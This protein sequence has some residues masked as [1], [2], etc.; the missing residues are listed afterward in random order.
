MKNKPSEEELSLIN[1]I[2]KEYLDKV[3]SSKQLSFELT[4]SLIYSSAVTLKQ[5]L[6]EITLKSINNQKS[7]KPKCMAQFINKI[8]RL[9]RITPHIEL[10]QK[11]KQTNS[12]TA[13]QTRICNRLIRKYCNIKQHTLT[14]HMTCLKQELR[15]TFSR[16]NYQKKVFERKRIKELFATNSRLV[17]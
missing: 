13:K 14:Y 15:A 8:N 17:Y 10:I 6:N 2:A 3:I 7:T 4:S 12:F 9:G 5:H 16:S 11:C 1:I